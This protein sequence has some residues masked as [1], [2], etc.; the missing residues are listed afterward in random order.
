MNWQPIVEG[1][2]TGVSASVVIAA[3]VVFK[4]R[5]RDFFLK[6]RV[7]KN[8]QTISFGGGIHGAHVG[9]SNYTGISLV[10]RSV[11]LM[12]ESSNLVLNA[13]NE[14]KSVFPKRQ[15]TRLSKEQK[16]KIKAGEEV[17]LSQELAFGTSWHEKDQVTGFVE[18]APY[19]SR[20]WNLHPEINLKS[21]THLNAVAVEIE[22]RTH[23]G[24]IEVVSVIT[25]G[26]ID[27]LK[28]YI[29]SINHQLA[30]G[31]FNHARKLFGLSPIKGFPTKEK[32]KAEA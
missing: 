31:S 28:S 9:L 12:A 7:I 24:T 29:D 17:L 32:E 6:R 19:T 5:I 1:I 8:C 21:G 26:R 18:L 20:S 3:A 10:I 23:S 16:R 30:E 27:G 22:Y 11:V 25:D 4:D 14:V 15:K 13:S 2:I